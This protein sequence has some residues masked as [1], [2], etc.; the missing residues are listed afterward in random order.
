MGTDDRKSGETTGRQ[1]RRQEGMREDRK[2]G[3][4]TGRQERREEGRRIVQEVC[5]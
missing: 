2:A 1:E 4:M 5:M 3:E